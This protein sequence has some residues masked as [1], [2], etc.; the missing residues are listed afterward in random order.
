M[1]AFT[2]KVVENTIEFKIAELIINEELNEGNRIKSIGKKKGQ[3]GD[4][5]I[6]QTNTPTT[7][8]RY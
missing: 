6:V 3:L 4:T 5:E 7:L 2:E 8:L 1:G